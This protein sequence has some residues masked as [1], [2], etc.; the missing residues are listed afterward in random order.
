MDSPPST[1][2]EMLWLWTSRPMPFVQGCSAKLLRSGPEQLS[3][4][5]GRNICFNTFGGR[6]QNV[7]DQAVKMEGSYLYW[8]GVWF[9]VDCIAKQKKLWSE[10][11]RNI[12]NFACASGGFV[13]R[14]R[15]WKE[16]EICGRKMKLIESGQNLHWIPN[17]LWH[18]QA[19]GLRN[20]T[21]KISQFL[22]I[23]DYPKTYSKFRIYWN[24]Y[25]EIIWND[26]NKQR[27]H[28]RD[29]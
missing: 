21:I 13:L 26:P 3:T 8:F 10:Y 17:W 9:E 25:W 18:P 6:S 15:Q 16:G 5:W 20:Q 19:S 22:P 2:K 27:G 29:N 12:W 24:N 14:C 23:S 4:Q 7:C 1:M 28:R 11:I